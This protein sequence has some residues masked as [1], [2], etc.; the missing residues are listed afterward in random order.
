MT[1]YHIMYDELAFEELRGLRA[2]DRKAVLRTIERHLRHEPTRE[3][4]SAIKRLDPPVL[5]VYRLRA[6]DF[7]VFYD[8]DEPNTVVR[9]IAVRYK[10]RQSLN[11]AAH[12]SRD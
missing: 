6:G 3:S 11:E 10:G 8:V 1:R 2:F 7:R 12:G 4:R 9:V 5:A